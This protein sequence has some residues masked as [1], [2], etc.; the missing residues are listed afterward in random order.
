MCLFSA[1]YWNKYF[2]LAIGE[3]CITWSLIKATDVL[4]PNKWA[5]NSISHDGGCV[6]LYISSRL[7]LSHE[8]CWRLTT[9]IIAIFT[10]TYP[11]TNRVFSSQFVLALF[12]KEA[13]LLSNCSYATVLQFQFIT[14]SRMNL[15]DLSDKAT[16]QTN[17]QKNHRKTGRKKKR[18]ERKQ[19]EQRK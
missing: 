15:A 4:L 10:I 7:Y 11:I 2:L 16:K 19:T 5:E 1:S 9:R 12:W 17:K 18:R 8:L 14:I 6:I 13:L 3:N